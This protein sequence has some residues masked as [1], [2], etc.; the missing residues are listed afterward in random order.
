MGYISGSD[1]RTALAVDSVVYFSQLECRDRGQ[2]NQVLILSDWTS[3]YISG[4]DLGTAQD[5]QVLIPIA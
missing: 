3:G 1:I 2:D 5:N 4:S